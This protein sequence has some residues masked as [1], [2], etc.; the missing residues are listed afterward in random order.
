MIIFLCVDDGDSSPTFFN[1]W[2]RIVCLNIQVRLITLL[3]ECSNLVKRIHVKLIWGFQNVIENQGSYSLCRILV[4]VCLFGFVSVL[5]R[6]FSGFKYQLQNSYKNYIVFLF[7]FLPFSLTCQ[8]FN[9]DQYEIRANEL[10]GK[11]S[12]SMMTTQFNSLL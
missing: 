8:N 9:N 12:L 10:V 6:G 5:S 2:S 11:F 4:W 3:V 1:S 7:T